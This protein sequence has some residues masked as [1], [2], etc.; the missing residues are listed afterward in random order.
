MILRDSVMII[1]DLEMI[2]GAQNTIFKTKC[3]VL[4][5]LDLIYSAMGTLSI[6]HTENKEPRA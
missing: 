6:T 5:A 3:I 2:Y 1:K 4:V